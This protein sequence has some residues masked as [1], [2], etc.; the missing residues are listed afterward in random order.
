MSPYDDAIATAARH[1]MT[2]VTKEEF[3]AALRADPR[4]IHPTPGQAMSVWKV[5]GTGVPWH[6]FG[7]TAPG[8]ANG[9]TAAGQTAPRFFIVKQS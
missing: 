8:Y 7:V 2:E 1:G 9:W 5:I 6:L 3:F 4:N